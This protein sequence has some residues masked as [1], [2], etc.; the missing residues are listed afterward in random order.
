MDKESVEL[1]HLPCVSKLRGAEL[2]DLEQIY[3]ERFGPF[4]GGVLAISPDVEAAR[5]AVQEGFA[6]AV[7]KRR[8][9]RGRGSLEGW[10]WRIV[11]N[12]AREVR[13]RERRTSGV[14]E[15]EVMSLEH[16]PNLRASELRRELRAL[17]ERQ[18]LAIFLHYYGD[19]S[20][21]D[22][23]RLLGVRGSGNCRGV[24]PCSARHAAR[25]RLEGGM[26]DDDAH[27]SSGD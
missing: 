7:A 27:R 22:V 18:R 13:R 1:E 17:P 16:V 8:G 15:T 11:L 6:R 12:A 25:T 23:A 19:L 5:D 9:Y 21:D 2:D 26:K 14:R 3:R 4:V 20:Y 10:V 24:A